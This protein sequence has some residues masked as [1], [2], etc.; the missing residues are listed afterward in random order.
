MRNKNWS[1]AGNAYCDTEKN[2]LWVLNIIKGHMLPSHILNCAGFL[3]GQ[4][5]A[6]GKMKAFHA[7]GLFLLLMCTLVKS[8]HRGEYCS[9]FF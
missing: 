3:A 7:C 9:F 4:E 5:V 6:L 8:Y 1:S 2:V